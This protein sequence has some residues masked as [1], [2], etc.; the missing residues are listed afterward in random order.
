MPRSTAARRI[1]SAAGAEHGAQRPVAVSLMPIQA[2]S[3]M[4]HCAAGTKLLLGSMLCTRLEGKDSCALLAVWMRCQAGPRRR[5]FQL[6]F[7]CASAMFYGLIFCGVLGLP[8]V[9]GSVRRRCRAAA[10]AD[11]ALSAVP[12]HLRLPCVVSP[13]LGAEKR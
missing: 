2:E 8:S 9:S 5:P 10:C 6:R 3:S 13:P 7:V 12:R 1:R 11:V 4:R